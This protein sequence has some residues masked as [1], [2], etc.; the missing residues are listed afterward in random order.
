MTMPNP[1]LRICSRCGTKHAFTSKNCPTCKEINRKR[2]IQQR[3][4]QLC[5]P[6]AKSWT[7]SLLL[8]LY[9]F[10]VKGGKIATK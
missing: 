10:V 9:S 3:A 6:T 4:E 7:N 2:Y 8:R 5:S 1:N